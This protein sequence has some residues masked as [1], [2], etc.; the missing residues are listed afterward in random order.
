MSSEPLLTCPACSQ[1][2]LVRMIGGGAG[3]IFK[4]SGFYKTDYKKDSSKS[5]EKEK[6]PASEKKSE[7]SSGE[8]TSKEKPAPSSDSKTDSTKKK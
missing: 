2:A 3:F 7:S 1:N 5:Q 6:S 4:G 8:K